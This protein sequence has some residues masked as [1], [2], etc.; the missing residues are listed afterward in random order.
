MPTPK[1]TPKPKPEP[2]PKPTPT[3]TPTQPSAPPL[4]STNPEMARLLHRLAYDVVANGDLSTLTP[5]DVRLELERRLQ[6]PLGQHKEFI[7]TLVV[8]VARE[9]VERDLR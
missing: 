4:F 2:E 9:V 8:Q 6:V 1:S 5:H 7:D 3:P